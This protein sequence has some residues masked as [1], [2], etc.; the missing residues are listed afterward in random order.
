MHFIVKKVNLLQYYRIKY[1]QIRNFRALFLSSH[2]N[3]FTSIS[4]FFNNKIVNYL[5]AGSFF[6]KYIASSEA[7]KASQRSSTLSTAFPWLSHRI[8]TAL[9]SFNNFHL[10]AFWTSLKILDLTVPFF[11]SRY[12]FKS[13][14][15]CINLNCSNGCKLSV[16]RI[17]QNKIKHHDKSRPLWS[18]HP[19]LK[20]SC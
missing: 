19:C 4:N 13:C 5:T 9:I 11:N 6:L 16:L 2:K 17:A 15:I 3:F 20:I 12:K 7:T 1:V 18:N 14:S 10:Y 8:V